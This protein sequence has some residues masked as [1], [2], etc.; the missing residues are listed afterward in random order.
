MLNGLDVLRAWCRGALFLMIGLLWT[1]LAP[2][3]ERAADAV[4]RAAHLQMLSERVVRSYAMLGQGVNAPRARAQLGAD[5][6]AFSGDLAALRGMPLNPAQKQALM[7]VDALWP[8]FRT[9]AQRAATQASGQALAQAGA[10]LQAAAADCTES[11]R[12]KAIDHFDAIGLA[13]SARTLSQRMAKFY[14]YAT[15]GLKAPEGTIDFVALQKEFRSDLDKL[16]IAP[17]N[18]DST[19]ADLALADSQWVFFAGALAQ[20]KGDAAGG[21]LK[22]QH[23][24]DVGK[25]S[26]AM[27]EVLEGLTRKYAASTEQD[28]AN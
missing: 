26:D 6:A 11:L 10:A 18:D 7:R 3:Q 9:A 17:Q 1:P 5:L 15:W 14:F 16:S 19:Q 23:M 27:L 21:P 2:A 28:W 8:G 20:L 25:T 22:M 24:A 12:V 13:G 4:N